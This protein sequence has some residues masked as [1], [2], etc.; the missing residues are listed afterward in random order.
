MKLQCTAHGLARESDG[1]SEDA[2]QLLQRD[3]STVVALADGL[4][5]AKEGRTAARRAVEM[6]TD[7]YA[8]KPLAWRPRRA[9][10]EF[11][12]QI[13][14]V[15]YQESQ[16]RYGRPELLCTLSV[17]AFEGNHAYGLNVG[18]SPI[19]L[20]R[21]G[22]LS[23]LS[24]HHALAHAGLEHV[25]TR[26]I[27]LTDTVEPAFFEVS[28]EN[29]DLILLCSD[30]VSNALPEKELTALLEH[31][32]SARTIVNAARQVAAH[33]E[34]LA[35]DA[36]AVVIEISADAWDSPAA[37]RDVEFLPELRPGEAIDDYQL[38][39]TLQEGDRVWLA[40]RTD[41]A[42]QVL[43]FPPREAQDDEVRRDAF[44]KE[45]WQATRAESPDFV[46]AFVPAG[47]T[48][49]YYGMDYVDAPTLQSLI[50]SAPL[51]TEE[52]ITL[53]QF[54]LRAEQFLLKHDL[55]H[56]DIKP[57]NILCL[58]TNSGL[59]FKLLDLG[60][61]AELFSVTSRSGTA[62]YLSP[63]RFHGAAIS[64]R[65]EIFAIGVTL[66]QAL[67]RTF[68]Y[69]EIE[70]F[71]TPRFDAVPRL[72]P[73]LNPSVPSWLNS[74]VFRALAP[75]AERRYQ[76]FSEMAYDLNHPENVTPYHRKDAPLL[77]RNPLLLYKIL[78]A[79]LFMSNLVLIYLLCT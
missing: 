50:A 49:R 36:T 34:E 27:G 37:R 77:E 51:R 61:V 39:R 65:T 3:E 31:R 9:L 17:V 19:F 2:Y 56:G 20:W 45:A 6:V 12:S 35:D 18:D 54:L 28:L 70:R 30:G 57:E 60:S 68:P 63:E 66:Y 59:E 4:G 67:T 52:T 1:V 32:A 64:E 79:A 10:T 8:A 41:G 7:Y 69:G 62:S 76:N 72:I 26:A 25:L 11:A 43:K 53:A 74:I 38:V 44:L 47:K 23:R 29:G 42:M 16:L 24:E 21:R 55:A 33:D 71:Q 5:S 22:N 75:E 78:C 73:D 46:R 14:R 13:N 58:R 40:K 15:L 48:L